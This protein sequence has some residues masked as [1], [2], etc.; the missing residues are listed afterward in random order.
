MRTKELKAIKK[1]IEELREHINRYIEYPDIF[2][3]ELLTTSRQLDK[4]I[5]EYMRRSMPS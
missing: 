5:N 1:K 3:E 2:E 4:Y